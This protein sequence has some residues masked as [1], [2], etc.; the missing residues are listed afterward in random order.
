MNLHRPA[1]L[2]LAGA[3]AILCAADAHAG[4]IYEADFEIFTPG[5]D[6]L[7]GTDGW[8]ATIN[9]QSLHGIDD[10]II[11]GL[12]K[13]AYLGFYPPTDPRTQT[14]SVFRPLNFDPIGTGNPIV[15]FEAII[16]IAQSQDDPDTNLSD[17]SMLEDRFLLSIYNTSF[18]LLA[19]IIYD[20]RTN[21]Y[22]LHRNNGGQSIDTNFEF[23]IEEPQF[24]FFSIDFENNTWSATLDGA[25][26]FTDAIFNNNG[27][28]RD[29]GTIAAEWNITSR[30]QF[31][32]GEFIPGNNWMLFDDWFVAAKSRDSAPPTEPFAVS[33]VVH[34]S[35]NQVELT[36]PADQGCTYRIQYST[37]LSTWTELP[38][39]PVIA[40]E[41]NPVATHIDPAPSGPARYY[42]IL[43]EEGD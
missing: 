41:S 32:P 16:A 23:I 20:T 7:A 27:R 40:E 17:E 35:D 10:E 11:P 34:T 22:G 13:S 25:P 14:I 37:N 43:R 21:T 8:V 4:V 26:I 3:M 30:N 42:R 36:Y 2:A 5:A 6:E 18:E 31:R 12:G 9:G 39:S 1:A 29:L 15:E 19:A 33:K 38:S 28:T 24:L